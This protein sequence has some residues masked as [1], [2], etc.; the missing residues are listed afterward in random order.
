MKILIVTVT[1]L[2][3]DFI[4]G[5]TDIGLE[6]DISS[7]IRNLCNFYFNYD[8]TAVF[9]MS[10][11]EN[12]CPNLKSDYKKLIDQEWIYYSYFYNYYS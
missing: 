10:K 8:P 5:E 11:L 3:K 12:L 4:P 6:C 1:I 7:E 2:G 9:Y